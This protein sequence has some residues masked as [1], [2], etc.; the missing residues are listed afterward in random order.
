MPIKKPKE[1]FVMLLSDVRQAAERENKILQEIGQSN[2]LK[3]GRRRGARGFE[4]NRFRLHETLRFD[5]IGAIPVDLER[6]SIVAGNL[7]VIEQ[8]GSVPVQ[9]DPRLTPVMTTQ[10]HS[11]AVDNHALRM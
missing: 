10:Q 1:V 9:R 5:W 2:P 3:A 8:Q 6:L 7:G 11:P 4:Y